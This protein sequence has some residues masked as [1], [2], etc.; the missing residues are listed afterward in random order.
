MPA[1]T[2]EQAQ[3][4]LDAWL[5][6]SLALAEGHQTYTVHG[7]TFSKAD[8]GEVRRQID[9]WE[10]KVNKLSSGS[11]GAKVRYVVSA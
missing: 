7:R 8:A 6:C 5:A 10:S 2:A 4:Q 3:A 11:R 9:Y 1:I